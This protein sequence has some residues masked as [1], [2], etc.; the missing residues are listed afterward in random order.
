MKSTIQRVV[1]A[2]TV[3]ALGAGTMGTAFAQTNASSAPGS[4]PA[5]HGHHGHFGRFHGS[6]FVGSLLRATK[7]LGRAPGTQN[8]A[9]SADQ[10]TY[11]KGL[12]KSARSGHHRGT[13]Q[14]PDITV[15]GN[16]TSS[17]FAAAVQ[18]AQATA[19]ARIQQDS[20]LAQSIWGDLSPGQQAA[21][22]GLLASIRAQEQARRAQWAGKHATGN[23]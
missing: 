3:A 23:G 1:F 4:A 22:P 9:L 14:A 21:I 17:G 20:T 10:Q 13:Q 5:H 11:I 16:P 19:T 7:Q 2:V 6:R 15:V 8:L 18:S 12:L